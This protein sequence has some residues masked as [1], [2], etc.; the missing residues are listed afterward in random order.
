MSFWKKEP[1]A[2]DPVA[3]A[4]AQ[5]QSNIATANANANLN[6]INQYNPYGSMTYTQNG[7]NPDGTPIWEQHVNLNP[8]G[9]QLL[10]LQQTQD[11]GLGKLNNQMLGQVASAYGQPIDTSGIAQLQSSAGQAQQSQASQAD[12]R[13]ASAYLA[14]YTGSNAERA[15]AQQGMASNAAMRQASYDAPIQNQLDTSDVPGLVGG[16]DLI[17]MQDQVKNALYGQQSQFLDPQWQQSD[18]TLATNLADQGIVQGSEAYDKAMKLQALN[19]NN[20]YQQAQMGAI[21]NANSQA[22]NLFNMGLASNQNAFGQALNKGQFANSAQA[23]GFGQSLSNA[24]LAS[25]IDQ[26]NAAQ[27][28][29][30]SKF[31]AN[32]GT[33]NSQFNANLGTQNNQFNAG[34]SNQNAQFNAGNSTDVSKFNAGNYNQNQQ[35]NAGQNTQNSQFNASQRNN[36]QQY[37]ANLNNASNAQGMS[38]LF[39]LRNQ[40]MNEFNAIRAGSQIQNPQFQGVPNVNV[41][42]TDTM[43]PVYNSYQG[44]LSSSNNAMGGL[45]QLGGT[46]LGSKVGQAGLSKLFGL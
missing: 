31:N 5:T 37:N 18:Q 1:P 7:K 46:L 10:D 3:V 21:T 16:H 11:V 12:M 6:R 33:Q 9:Q 20:A 35:F 30:M 45:F 22:Q 4:N 8:M 39:A 17:T 13:D 26:F 41:A 43:T 44:Q 32:L 38:N 23:Q 19:K 29:D 15:Q 2:P 34:Q 42:N 14:G 25:A 28:N 27:N 24:Q 40:P 36:M